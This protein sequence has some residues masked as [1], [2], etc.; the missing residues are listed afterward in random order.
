MKMPTLEEMM[1]AGVHF[2]HRTSKWNPKIKPYIYGVK[3]NV[4]IFDLEKSLE[5]LEKALNFVKE[6]IAK[7]GVVLFVGTK[8]QARKIVEKYA[9][10]VEMPYVVEGWIGGTITN[11]AEIR[12]LVKKLESLEEKASD[13]AYEVKYTKKERLVFSQEAA[14]LNKKIGGIRNMKK[15][16]EVIYVVGARDEK[17]VLREAKIKKVE[18][19]GIVDTNT[20]PESVDYPIMANDDAIKSLEMMTNLMAEAVKEGKKEADKAE[21]EKKAKEV[22]KIEKE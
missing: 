18:T 3:N 4:H 16:P 1:Q 19:A 22:K 5:S 6:T 2:G 10:E 11:F 8:K 17:T 12:R 9:K 20:D 13:P 7:G 14:I 21:E 15:L